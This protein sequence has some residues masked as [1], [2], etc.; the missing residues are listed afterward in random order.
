MKKSLFFLLLLPC[1]TFSQTASELLVRW[2]GTRINESL[3]STNPMYYYN[4]PSGTLAQPAAISALNCTGG[5]SINFHYEPYTGFGGQNWTT[6][7]TEEYNK[8]F[9]FAVAAGAGKKIQAKHFKFTYKGYCSAYKVIYQI[10]DNSAGVPSENS[11]AT[12]GT[13]LTTFTNANASSNE[14]AVPLTFSSGLFI[15]SN[16]TMYIRIYPYQVNQWN[17]N[18]FMK[19][20]Q[21]VNNVGNVNSIG[22]AFYGVVSDASGVTAVADTD[23]TYESA[24]ITKNV[25]LNDIA[26]GTTIASVQIIAPLLNGVDGTASVNGNS[27]T[28]NPTASLGEKTI[29]YKITGADGS[30]STSTYKVTV[31][32][33]PSPT[34]NDDAATTGKNIPATIAVTANDVAGIGT[35]GTITITTQ[36]AT[37]AG[38]ASVSG[39]NIIFTPTATFV[40]TATIKYRV[41]NSQNKLSNIATI[42]VT[43]VNIT[44]VVANNDTVSTS[45]NNAVTFNPLANDVAGNSA[46][47]GIAV[48]ANPAHGSVMVNT[49]ANTFTYTPDANY[50]GTDSFT[51]TVTDAYNTSSTATVSM[52]VLQPTTTGALCGTYAIGTTVQYDY[53]QFT[54]ITAAV[55]HLNANG[56][57]CPVTFLLIDNDYNTVTGESFP[58]VINQ[59][60]GTSLTNTVTFKP[61]PA[62]NVTVKVEDIWVD[63]VKYQA[64]TVFQLN[65]ADNIIFDGSNTAN[66]TTRNLT[67]YNNNTIEYLNR[68]VLWVAANGSNGSQNVTVKHTNLRQGYRNQEGMY[69]LGVFAGNN[70][71]ENATT[72][73]NRNLKVSDLAG[74]NNSNLY[75][76]NNDFINTKQGVYVQGNATNVTTGVNVFQNDLGAE[77]NQESVILPVSLNNVSDFSVSENLVYNLYR[78]TTAADLIAGGINVKGNSANGSITKNNLRELQRLTA[79]A[80]TFAGIVL[81]ANSANSNIL[82]ANNFIL[83]PRAKGNGGGYSNGYG[84]IVD[85]GGGY[86]ILHNTVVLTTNQELPGYSAALY[87]NSNVSNLDVRNNIFVNNQTHTGTVRSAIMVNNDVDNLNTIFTKLDYNNYYSADKIGYIANI[88][89]LNITWP[90]NPDFVSLLSGWTG[91]LNATNNAANA[92]NRDAHSISI[93]PAFISATD[94]HLASD[95]G[96]MNDKGT[97]IAE[98]PK[99]ID[100]QLRNTTTPDMGADEF[101]AITLPAPGSNAGIYCSSSTTWE[102]GAWSNG[103]PEY[104]KD[105]I[106]RSNKTYA[107]EDIQACSIFV[108]NGASVNFISE[109]NA[110]VTHNVNVEEGSSLTFESSCHLLQT[111]NTYNTGTV[112]IK[113]NSSKLKRLDYVMWS[114][115]VFGSQTLHD[116]SPNTLDNRFYTYS[117][118]TNFYT[119]VNAATTTFAKAKSFLIRMPNNHS[120][121]TPTV[122]PAEFE[123]TPNNGNVYYPLEYLDAAHSFNAVGNPYPSPI[124]VTAFID[125]NLNNITGTLWVW[126]KTNDYTE[127]SY[128]TITKMGYTANA[129]P[130]GSSQDNELVGDPFEITNAG[131]LNTAQGFIVK[132][133]GAQKN[134]VFRNNMRLDLNYNNFFRNANDAETPVQYEWSRLWL[135]VKGSEIGYSQILVGYSSQT[136]LGYD[137]GF[138]G[139]A[140]SGGNVNL[141]S[142]ITD[143][144]EQKKLAIQ[145]RPSFTNAD[146]VPLG[147]TADVAGTFTFELDHVDGL[148]LGSQNIYLVDNLTNTFHN[149][150]EG[151]YTFTT[152]VG[153]FDDRFRIVYATDE[154]LGTEVPA[155]DAKNVIVYRDGKQINITAPQDIQSV[156]VY[157]MLGRVLYENNNVNAAKFV[158]SNIE[159]SQQ[160][161]IVKMTTADRQVVSKKIMMN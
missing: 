44:P 76:W 39:S 146:V 127:S 68:S 150:K 135:N 24:P 78:T 17:N 160:V 55:N 93:N 74:G 85:N 26:Q 58:L 94:L 119:N 46:I 32:A 106:F 51:Y 111:E 50:T 49:P 70:Y 125:A 41:R 60:S 31:V 100:G 124:N 69:T 131:V 107:A 159:T 137:E 73:N 81:S 22:P 4:T 154:E 148:L 5:G 105:V 12:A 83:N 126:R 96:P 71:I 97:F 118:A 52:S 116:F 113:R 43:V 101:G 139:T 80:N 151:S 23:T 66:G 63:S 16:Q 110:Y 87:V 79:D 29:N 117:N 152:E 11:F 95:N 15:N 40:G 42:T 86:R 75:V 140:L 35:F 61:G 18:T 102:N 13:V 134:L 64:T 90:Q 129:A 142:V 136:G 122:F 19:F 59:F 33:Y 25:I 123:G 54:T 45:K 120:E 115:P 8:Y 47:T 3:P 36:P 103:T 48:L 145:A 82:V 2:E 65:G 10:V 109:S 132:A 161:V 121:T 149:I 104:G 62:K 72:W 67:L 84:I 147:F 130:G 28:Y 153:T 108:E 27:I 133:K 89:G 143:G 98:V 91:A 157:D 56:V 114:S 6:G 99:D 20:S 30:T 128:S 138:D 88:H 21:P 144:G 141:S 158:T 38:T 77:D 1:L 57:T 7:A 34:A 112:T 92:N 14:V 156:V 53:P 37:V 155:I 9:Q